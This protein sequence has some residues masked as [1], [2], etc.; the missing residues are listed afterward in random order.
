MIQNKYGGVD[1][2]GPVKP[3]ALNKVRR[4]WWKVLPD[5]A[6]NTFNDLFKKYNLPIVGWKTGEY[7]GWRDG[8]RPGQFGFAQFDGVDDSASGPIGSVLTNTYTLAATVF[9]A[10]DSKGCILRAGDT[11]QGFGFG[12]GGTAFENAGNN[13]LCLLESVRWATAK[14]TLGTGWFRIAIAISTTG[15]TA[16]V[17]GVQVFTDSAGGPNAPATF[18]VYIGG[19]TTTAG[20]PSVQRYYKGGVD[21]TTL[22]TKVLTATE[23]KEDWKQEQ[24]GFQDML[25]WEPKRRSVQFLLAGIPLTTVGITRSS[26]W[27][28]LE[29]PKVPVGVSRS[30]Y[31][32]TLTK[33]STAPQSLLWNV[34][35]PPP[36]PIQS[37]AL[38][39]DE[40]SDGVIGP[41]WVSHGGTWVETAG[42]VSQTDLA[43]NDPKR[44]QVEGIE[45]PTNI[46]VKARVRVDTWNT[47]DPTRFDYNRAGL[48]VGGDANGRGY[49]FLFHNDTSTVE[50]LYDGS[51]WGAAGVFNWSVGVWYWMRFQ[52]S[53]QTMSGKV[54]A[55]GDPEPTAWTV[56]DRSWGPRVGA[57]G[58][59]G[60]SNNGS[61]ASFD[62]FLVTDPTQTPLYAVGQTRSALWNVAA[63]TAP[64]TV[65]LTRSS[66]WNTQTRTTLT[67]SSY[68][69]TQTR[70]TVGLSRS[71][72]WDVRT[73]AL[74]WMASV[75]FRA[76]I[77]FVQD[78]TGETCSIGEAYTGSVI[79]DNLAFGWSG[80]YAPNDLAA[81]APYA[82]EFAGRVYTNAVYGG[83]IFRLDLPAPGTYAVRLAIGDTNPLAEVY[84]SIHDG[85]T[86]P[87]LATIALP[88]GAPGSNYVDSTGV[89][90]TSPDDWRMN[91]Q[92]VILTFTNPSL[93]LHLSDPADGATGITSIAHLDIAESV[94]AP[95]GVPVGLSGS[96]YWGVA[97]SVG[98]DGEQTWDVTHTNPV[99]LISTLTWDNYARATLFGT[100]LWNVATH[101]T[102][103]RVT[104]WNDYVPVART[105]DA[106]WS[107][108]LSVSLNATLLWDTIGPSGF[109]CQARWNVQAPVALSR[110]VLY[111]V[112][113]PTTI[114]RQAYWNIAANLA[115]QGT[116]L[117]NVQRG[118]AVAGAALWTVNTAE[119]ELLSKLTLDQLLNIPPDEWGP[120]GPNH[121]IKYNQ[122][123][124]QQLE[125]LN[126]KGPKS[127]RS[128]RFGSIIMPK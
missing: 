35:G 18:N 119:S 89:I 82:P 71:S 90:R 93:V 122:I 118:V 53:G 6:G 3:A 113:V 97:Q 100:T 94:S 16:Y 54:W 72:I 102:L 60:G 56:V 84:A 44:L 17:N 46:D 123:Y 95:V 109:L 105:A 110:S 38:Y 58:L 43:L 81:T 48:S 55:D 40:F 62:D 24:I 74:P 7:S 30:A 27:D 42:Q 127:G 37:N 99:G 86:G 26:Y 69:N 77:P 47:T 63:P 12:I 103:H 19:Y 117:W 78:A 52:D 96:A 20:G 59:N 111:D 114:T 2:N 98:V 106:T 14:T 107:S 108:T 10:S 9:V 57:P 85:P 101:V 13:L 88:G 68:W 51:S 39:H 83:G 128:R 116:P 32:N 8:L 23:F 73:A 104:Y 29:A 33:I 112:T 36:P 45:F 50:F 65:G 49:N 61:T 87:I 92:P 11:D 4:G 67:R 31:W 22:Y 70:T 64:T 115:I 125:L 126:R 28:T 34:A 1:L 124:N 21:N 76:N 120:F 5:P 121:I 75:N 15:V 66:Y 79:R 41:D 80:A 91:N 25:N